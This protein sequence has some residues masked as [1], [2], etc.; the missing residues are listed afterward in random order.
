MTGKSS[1]P[2]ALIFCHSVREADSLHALWNEALLQL[3]NYIQTLNFSKKKISS[4]VYDSEFCLHFYWGYFTGLEPNRC[5]TLKTDA[6]VSNCFI[7]HNNSPTLR[8]HCMLDSYLTAS[9]SQ[10]GSLPRY[11]HRY[12]WTNSVS[13]R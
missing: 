8:L 12:R 7:S 11:K 5:I 6:D 2:T 13:V 9:A 4:C 1:P 3:L 10:T